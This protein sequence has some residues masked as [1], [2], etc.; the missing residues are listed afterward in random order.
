MRKYSGDTERKHRC[1]VRRADVE[2]V[3]ERGVAWEKG[4]CVVCGADVWTRLAGRGVP[5]EVVDL[6]EDARGWYVPV[7]GAK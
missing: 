3:T 7:W 2:T 1:K 4:A 5:L 6:V